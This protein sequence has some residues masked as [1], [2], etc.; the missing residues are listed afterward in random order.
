MILDPSHSST[1]LLRWSPSCLLT[2]YNLWQ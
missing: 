1:P 2:D